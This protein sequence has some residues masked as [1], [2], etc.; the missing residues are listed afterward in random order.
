M[1]PASVP[2]S[3]AQHRAL[4]RDAR[5]YAVIGALIAP[6]FLASLVWLVASIE[7]WDLVAPTLAT[8]LFGGSLAAMLQAAR[9][10]LRDARAGQAEVR[11]LQLRARIDSRR[12][13]PR[14]T[15]G[16]V[17]MLQAHAAAA[18]ALPATPE[19]AWYR[20]TYSPHS[21]TLWAIEPA[22]DD[23]TPMV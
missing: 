14:L 12:T 4:I 19:G 3:A 10:S 1:T 8:A 21:A 20:V 16:E 17:G 18:D 22:P 15:F 2:L 5:S 13:G 11:R 9:Q 6:F 23:G 7:M